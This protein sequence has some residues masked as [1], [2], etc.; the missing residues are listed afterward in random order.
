MKLDVTYQNDKI[1]F[2]HLQR[3]HIK[4]VYLSIDKEKGIV[5]K[6]SP[7]FRAEDAKR[8]VL[9]KAEWI[10]SK[11]ATIDSLITTQLPP[12]EELSHLYL[13]GNRLP[14]VIKSDPTCKT[15]RIYQNE[16]GSYATFR[17]N[18]PSWATTPFKNCFLPI[19]K[20]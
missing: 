7:Y 6:S 1:S 20:E 14:V 3:K 19:F 13:D 5:V 2:T 15:V 10:R 11:L 9:D 8:M 17:P 4:N 18:T 16:A 12:L